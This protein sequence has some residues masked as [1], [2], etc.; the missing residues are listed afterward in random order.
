M[1]SDLTHWITQ[2]G[3][4]VLGTVFYP[5]PGTTDFSSFLLQ[6]Q[7]S[8]ADVIGL[9]NAGGDFV[10]CVKQATEFGIK[11]PAVRLAGTAVFINSIRA[12]GLEVAQGLTY[13]ECF[14]WDRDER[15][16]A[17]TK[18]AVARTPDNY[19]NQIHAG[20]YSATTHYLKAVSQLGAVNAKASGAATVAAMKAMPTDDDAFGPGKIRIDGRHIHPV[21]LLQVKAPSDS[22][23]GWD[24]CRIAQVTPADEAFR[25]LSDG[26]CPLVKL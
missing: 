14:Y 16:R 17:F 26:N 3:G 4:K 23:G 6:A 24:F 15:S 22:R 8:G 2:Y 25:P 21:Y 1:Q 13:S 18:R 19:P 11:S 9:L 7:A 12:L 20:D 5:F 10:N